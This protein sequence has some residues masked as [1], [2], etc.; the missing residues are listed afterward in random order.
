MGVVMT[1]H[2]QQQHQHD[3]EAVLRE[4]GISGV[5]VTVDETDAAWLQG[6]VATREEEAA[7][8]EAATQTDVSMVI[9]NLDHPYQAEDAGQLPERHTHMLSAESRRAKAPASPGV[10]ILR[11][12]DL[13]DRLFDAEAWPPVRTGNSID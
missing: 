10:T 9:D 8:V 2:T 6:H 1:T 5:Q 4:R 13:S 12:A 7:A 3:I 11:G